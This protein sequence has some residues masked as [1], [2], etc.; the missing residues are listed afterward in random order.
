MYHCSYLYLDLLI[1]TYVTVLADTHKQILRAYSHY[2]K[3][4][5]L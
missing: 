3:L 4:D 1:V 5:K 2:L